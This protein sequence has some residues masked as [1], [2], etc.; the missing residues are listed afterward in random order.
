MVRILEKEQ[1]LLC[2]S[3]CD[4]GLS[5]Q[6]WRADGHK[7]VSEGDGEEIHSDI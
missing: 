2:I 5:P 1:L 7:Q 3:E 6:D 4:W